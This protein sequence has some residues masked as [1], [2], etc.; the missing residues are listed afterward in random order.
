MGLSDAR[1]CG[2]QCP[3]FPF[4]MLLIYLSKGYQLGLLG[5]KG[6]MPLTEPGENAKTLNPRY[7]KSGG[8]NQL[9][10]LYQDLKSEMS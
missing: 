4:Q 5:L 6:T 10:Q 7:Q 3:E 2:I 1:F 9:K 8:A